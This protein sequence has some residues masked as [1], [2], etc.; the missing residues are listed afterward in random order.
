MKRL[1]DSA[2]TPDIAPGQMKE[3]GESATEYAPGQQLDDDLDDDTDDTTTGSTNSAREFAPGQQDEP[4]DEMAPGQQDDPT[5][6]APGQMKKL[7]EDT[8]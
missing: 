8:D 6:A 7:D 5:A 1:D 4:A 2:G 3:E